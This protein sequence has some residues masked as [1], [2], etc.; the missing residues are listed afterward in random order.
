MVLYYKHNYFRTKKNY[1]F[2]PVQ[3]YHLTVEETEAQL[4][5]FAHSRPLG[6]FGR[7]GGNGTHISEEDLS[8]DCLTSPDNE[9]GIY[10]NYFI[11]IDFYLFSLE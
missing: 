7:E 10:F 2:P 6:K 3:P 5:E 11:D 1:S 4:D 9:N 8:L